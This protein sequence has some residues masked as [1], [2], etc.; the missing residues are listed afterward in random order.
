MGSWWFVCK[1]CMLDAWHH[2]AADDS[3]KD[4]SPQTSMLRWY[5]FDHCDKC[6]KLRWGPGMYEFYHGI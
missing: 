5:E 2:H 3:F 4:I 6:K 1:K